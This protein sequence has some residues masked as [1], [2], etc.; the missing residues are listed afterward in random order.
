MHTS[1]SF[2]VHYTKDTVFRYGIIVSKTVGNSV[3]RHRKYRQ[4][5]EIIRKISSGSYCFAVVIRVKQAAVEKTFWELLNELTLV[6]G[7]IEKE[8]LL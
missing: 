6:F 7:R 3:V 5:R 2:S 8:F 1:N 4:F